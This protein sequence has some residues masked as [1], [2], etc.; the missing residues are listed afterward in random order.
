MYEERIKVVKDQ[1]KS[2][3]NQLRLSTDEE[4][5]KL[6][7]CHV[8]EMETMRE[9]L[10]THAGNEGAV[11]SDLENEVGNLRIEVSKTKAERDAAD[12]YAADMKSYAEK[13]TMQMR[14]ILH[15]QEA[16]QLMI[17][18]QQQELEKSNSRREQVIQNLLRQAEEERSQRVRGGSDMKNMIEVNLSAMKTM[19]AQKP[20]RFERNSANSG[21]IGGDSTP[22][23]SSHGLGHHHTVHSR[24]QLHSP[25]IH[26][27]TIHNPNATTLHGF[28]GVGATPSTG[29]NYNQNVIPHGSTKKKE[30]KGGNHDPHNVG[31]PEA[32]KDDISAITDCSNF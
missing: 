22:P 15:D 26:Q 14:Q 20:E 19:I 1:N 17:S 10:N 32:V 7:N 6:I 11:I 28:A 5:R 29:N 8:Q 4:K 12:L 18:K 3:M 31:Y 13:L 25:P 2:N 21:L 9:M 16:L 23:R 27:T 30:A 24:S